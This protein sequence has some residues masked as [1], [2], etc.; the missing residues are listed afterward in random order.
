MRGGFRDEFGMCINVP[1]TRPNP[2]FSNRGKPKPELKLSQ[3]GFSPSKR[4][5][6]GRVPADM[7]FIAMSILMLILILNFKPLNM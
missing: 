6:F 2:I 7:S 4:L 1:I 3:L 5:L